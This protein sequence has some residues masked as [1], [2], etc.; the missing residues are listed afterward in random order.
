VIALFRELGEA[1][2]QDQLEH[3][4]RRS[5]GDVLV[6]VAQNVGRTGDFDRAL[7][8]ATAAVAQPEI[9]GDPEYGAELWQ[10][11]A[12]YHLQDGTARRPGQLMLIHGR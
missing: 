7:A 11:I 3:A 12:R 4:T 9:A 5:R 6:A 1:R 2:I 8:Y 10:R